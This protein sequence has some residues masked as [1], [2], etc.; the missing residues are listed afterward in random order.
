V[1]L[2]IQNLSIPKPLGLDSWSGAHRRAEI[3]SEALIKRGAHNILG[4]V[5]APCLAKRIKN[6]RYLFISILLY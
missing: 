1:G 2:I 5:E 3:C 4:F 6:L